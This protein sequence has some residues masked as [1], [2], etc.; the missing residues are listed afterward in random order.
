M[1]IQRL[2][3]FAKSIKEV[4]TVDDIRK[5][6]V[7]SMGYSLK[8]FQNSDA[9]D[10][11]CYFQKLETTIVTGHFLYKKFYTKDLQAL[12]NDIIELIL[13]FVQIADP[14]KINMELSSQEIVSKDNIYS[15]AIEF[16]SQHLKEL[17]QEII[18]R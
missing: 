14:E 12:I 4:N 6:F 9:S 18:L 16:E 11:I 7:I 1:A 10:L 5:T 2:L 3:A 13:P 8:N 15:L 17:E